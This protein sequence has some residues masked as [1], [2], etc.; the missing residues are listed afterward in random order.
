MEDEGER[1]KL[2]VGAIV[3]GIILVVIVFFV[4][5]GL[6]SEK[7]IEQTVPVVTM[8]PTQAPAQDVT[9]SP[10][11]TPTPIIPSN[12]TTREGFTNPGQQYVQPTYYYYQSQSSSGNSS[13]N[14]S[15]T[16]QTQ[17][18]PNGMTQTQSY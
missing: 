5:K 14:Q 9:T 12:G 3:V 6:T 15:G 7:S 11:P 1:S 17:T 13:Q 2:L 8:E 10:T 16:T 4:I 18:L